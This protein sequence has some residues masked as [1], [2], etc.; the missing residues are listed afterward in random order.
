MHYALRRYQWHVLVSVFL[1]RCLGASQW[2]L[3]GEYF[4]PR[5][6]LSSFV[7][8]RPQF[9]EV[10]GYGEPQTDRFEFGLK[11]QWQFTGVDLS[12][13]GAQLLANAPTFDLANQALIADPY[14]LVGF[15]VNKVINNIV[16]K[17][18]FAYKKDVGQLQMQASIPVIVDSRRVESAFGIEYSPKENQQY[19]VAFIGQSIV[20][21]DE[22]MVTLGS[23]GTHQQDKNIAQA[24]L[25][26]S[27]RYFNN[28]LALNLVALT[29]GN[30]ELGLLSGQL[31]YQWN[32]RWQVE[33]ALMGAWA[34]TKSQFAPTDGEGLVLIGVTY[35]H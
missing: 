12:F 27:D 35:A 21:Y 28:D 3:S 20:D 2:L 13:Y 22:D 32:D 16:L 10:P 14:Q 19:T 25:A 24:M 7:N 11:T 30:G 26:Y 33:G 23:S 1:F 17:W 6:T 15:S 34:D 18:D 5:L 29:S 31:S 8:V 9:T 4:M